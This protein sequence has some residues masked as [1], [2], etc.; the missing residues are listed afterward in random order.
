MVESAKQ[1][2]KSPNLRIYLKSELKFLAW[3]H[4]TQRQ[5]WEDHFT[6]GAI[7]REKKEKSLHMCYR[8]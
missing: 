8:G 5:V 6:L 3:V 2:E 4:N 1:E 7:D